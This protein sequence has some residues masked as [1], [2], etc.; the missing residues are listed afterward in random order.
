MLSSE[1]LIQARAA[2]GRGALGESIDHYLALVRGDRP[3]PAVL[4]EAAEVIG[5]LRPSVGELLARKALEQ[6]PLLPEALHAMADS[7]ARQGRYAEAVPLFRQAVAQ[8]GRLSE[9]KDAGTPQE[10]QP[11]R[12]RYPTVAC[13]ACGTVEGTLVHAGNASRVQR[14]YGVVDPV[15]LWL[16]CDDC[17]LVRVP[18]PPPEDR[19][20][21][22]YEAAYS[23]SPDTHNPP[24]MGPALYRELMQGEAQ[25]RRLLERFPHVRGGRLLEVGAAFGLFLAAAGYQGFDAVGLEL[26]TAAVQ[27]GT[28]RLGVDLR[29][30]SCPGD[31]PAGD[32][33]VI[34]LFE[35]IEHFLNPDAVLADLARRL[36]PGGVLLLSTPCLD[37]PYHV[38]AGYDDPMW[39]VPGH[40]VYYDRATLRAAL[41]RAGLR[42]A[43]RW[44][45]DRHLGSVMVAATPV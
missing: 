17:G 27:W 10:A 24:A 6:Q 36:R 39:S 5:P 35:V 30:G 1:R 20:P 40:L 3:T 41:G 34:V 28:A 4:A 15:K 21:A 29:Q 13:P 12:T 45:S 14:C 42:E 37:H 9:L 16:R 7:V 44:F 11:W 19:L 26:A 2:R 23:R 8:S 43:D 25:V 33:D 31:V 18:D 22:W 32:Y 38:A